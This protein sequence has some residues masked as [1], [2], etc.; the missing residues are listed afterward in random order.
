MASG[1]SGR[2]S[3]PLRKSLFQRSQLGE[4]ARSAQTN[5]LPQGRRCR[6]EARRHL[7]IRS[8]RDLHSEPRSL[9]GT[10]RD[11]KAW[12]PRAPSTVAVPGSFPDDATLADSLPF[13]CPRSLAVLLLPFALL[14]DNRSF[15]PCNGQRKRVCHLEVS[16]LSV[17]STWA[18]FG[19]AAKR[20]RRPLRG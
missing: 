20:I 15:R 19:A 3:Q 6:S 10:G 17:V 18:D 5:P 9:D 13:S 1:R 14:T 16:A 8:L 12:L 2:M 11:A 7:G 4:H